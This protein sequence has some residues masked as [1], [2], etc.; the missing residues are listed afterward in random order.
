MKVIHINIIKRKRKISEI[1][2]I[3]QLQ[4]DEKI[5]YIHH[6]FSVE[7]KNQFVALY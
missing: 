7:Y 4:K 3:K 6:V 2:F 1:K 5:I